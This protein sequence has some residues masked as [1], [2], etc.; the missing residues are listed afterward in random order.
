MHLGEIQQLPRAEKLK[1][2]E[3]LWADLA[4]D[5]EAVE[6]PE[7]HAAELRATEEALKR[8]GEEVID[9]S[10]AKRRLRAIIE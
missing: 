7:W 10:E 8:G 2:F 5:E 9:W 1:L 3:A 4:A 6:A